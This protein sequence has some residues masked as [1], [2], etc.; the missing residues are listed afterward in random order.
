MD[1]SLILTMI[2]PWNLKY[3][4]DILEKGNNDNEHVNKNPIKHD[5][6]TELSFYKVFFSS[7]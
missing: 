1:N 2:L 6:I 7:Y 4:K 3:L 5:D